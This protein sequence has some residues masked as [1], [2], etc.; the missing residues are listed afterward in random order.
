M[1]TPIIVAIITSAT[2]LITGAITAIVTVSVTKSLTVYRLNELKEDLA[3]LSVRVTKHNNVL[4]RTSV[5]E[6]DVKTAF[7]LIDENRDRANK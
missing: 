5:L 2:G 1:T 3:E 7:R 4:E 6:R